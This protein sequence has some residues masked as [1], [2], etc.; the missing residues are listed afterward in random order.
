MLSELLCS[1]WGLC[2]GVHAEASTEGADF[3]SVQ[4]LRSVGKWVVCDMAVSCA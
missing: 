1:M 3:S 2:S 4:L